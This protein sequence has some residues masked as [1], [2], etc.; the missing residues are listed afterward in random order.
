MIKLS[1]DSTL[2]SWD[3]NIEAMVSPTTKLEIELYTTRGL[4]SPKLQYSQGP[5]PQVVEMSVGD[6]KSGWDT[7]LAEIPGT[8]LES[9]TLALSVR[10]GDTLT[11]TFNIRVNVI[12][13]PAA[14]RD[15]DAMFVV[16]RDTRK[17]IIPSGQSF[18]AMCHDRDSE[19]LTF[20]VPRYAD[21]VDLSTKAASVHYMTGKGGSFSTAELTTKSV[22]EGYLILTWLVGS[23]VTYEVG[24]VKFGLEFQSPADAYPKYFWQTQPVELPVLDSITSIINSA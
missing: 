14:L 16:D 8:G 22:E 18:L 20:K 6:Y 10:S 12:E 21:G 3:N 24:L 4:V 1:L 11:N 2:H 7:Y 23:D 19:V 15:D 9:G 5:I 13:D 17:I